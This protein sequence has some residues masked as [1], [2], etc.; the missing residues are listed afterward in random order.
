M[1]SVWFI[2]LCCGGYIEQVDHVTRWGSTDIPLVVPH[3]GQL[4]LSCYHCL[5]LGLQWEA[6]N[7]WRQEWRNLTRKVL[8]LVFISY[9]LKFYGYI[10][11][12]DIH[13]T[14]LSTAKKLRLSFKLLTLTFIQVKNV[15]LRKVVKIILTGWCVLIP[16][17]YP[18][19]LCWDLISSVSI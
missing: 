11:L 16:P 10:N 4:L 13:K 1:R 6:R 14:K 15:I 12:P 8:E 2:F 19:S 9:R 3:T 5:Q 18:L 7:N 17:I